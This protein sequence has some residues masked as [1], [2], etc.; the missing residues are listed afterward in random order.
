MVFLCCFLSSSSVTISSH[1]FRS[2]L[3]TSIFWCNGWW[4][5]NARYW[6]VCVFFQYTFTFTDPSSFLSSKVPRNG[7]VLSVS[8][9]CVNLMLLQSTRSGPMSPHHK[10]SHDTA[11]CRVLLA[12]AMKW[13]S[14][15]SICVVHVPVKIEILIGW[16]ALCD[17]QS[18]QTGIKGQNL[19]VWF[20]RC[21]WR[22]CAWRENERD[23]KAV[24]TKL[25]TSQ[26]NDNTLNYW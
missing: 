20:D 16:S 23:Y 13:F 7:M 26:K 8:T 17:L 25:L 19:S 3:A 10:T 15:I 18:R 11:S 12:S 1:L 4:E 24:C 22:L 21:L 6:I 2:V 14:N 5:S 9:S